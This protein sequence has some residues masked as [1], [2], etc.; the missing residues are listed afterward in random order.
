[1]VS[2]SRSLKKKI[3]LPDQ[4]PGLTTQGSCVG[5]SF[6]IGKRT[7]KA[8]DIDV[9]RGWRVLTRLSKGGIYFFNWLL[10]INQKNVSSL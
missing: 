6:I 5:R 10:T 3:E 2:D 1:M 9:R 7:E 4:G 8:S